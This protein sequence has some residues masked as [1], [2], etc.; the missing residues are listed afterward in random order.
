MRSRPVPARWLPGNSS[1]MMGPD[2]TERPMPMGMLI[3]AAMRMEFSDT[4]PAS[5]RRSRAMA[6]EMA[7]TMEMVRGVIKAAGRLNRVWALP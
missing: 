1:P 4:A 2:R 7:G 3:A 6:P 5:C